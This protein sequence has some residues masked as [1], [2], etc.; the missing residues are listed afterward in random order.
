MLI[1]PA[2][3]T[4]E[5]DGGYWVR[6]PDLEGCMTE[7]ENINEA[8]KMAEEALGGYLASLLER[9]LVVPKAS[10][11]TSIKVDAT[12]GE[13]LAVIFSD[14]DKY[15]ASKKAVRKNVTIPGWLAEKA[16]GHCINYSAVL[17]DALKEK[18]GVAG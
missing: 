5:S 17:Q 11:P 16:D 9:D 2:I 18:L 12:L 10:E 7:G 14:V 13:F 8:A 6:F 1:Y 15:F 4:K 3:F